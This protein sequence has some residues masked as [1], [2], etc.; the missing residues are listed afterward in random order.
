MRGLVVAVVIILSVCIFQALEVLHAVHFSRRTPNE[1]FSTA[2][3]VLETSET[4]AMVEKVHVE[5]NGTKKSRVDNGGVDALV[6]RLDR[7]NVN[8]RDTLTGSGMVE[9][10]PSRIKTSELVPQNDLAT[11]DSRDT[12]TGRVEN[13][14]SGRA[15]EPE[16][17]TPEAESAC[18]DGVAAQCPHLLRSFETGVAVRGEIPGIDGPCDFSCIDRMIYS[19]CISHLNNAPI[20]THWLNSSRYLEQR[21]V[22]A[23]SATIR[24]D[25][26]QR[27]Y[28]AASLR[29]AGKV[30][31]KWMHSMLG[32]ARVLTH[33]NGPGSVFVSIYED[34]STDNTRPNLK[35]LRECLSD[36]SIPHHILLDVQEN[37]PAGM[38]IDRMAV[39]RERAL[40]KLDKTFDFVVF[41]N[42]INFIPENILQLIYTNAPFDM[43]CGMDHEHRFDSKTPPAKAS[44]RHF[45]DVWVGRDLEGKTMQRNFPWFAHPLDQMLASQGV[46]LPV[47]CCWNGGVVVRASVFTESNIHFR[48]AIQNDTLGECDDSECS[49]FCRDLWRCDFRAQNPRYSIN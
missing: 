43:V 25:Q 46:P 17:T 33:L 49:N 37:S 10:E 47:G 18:P 30:L 16:K 5:R 14:T 26:K 42:D 12:P 22:S 4:M 45:Y 36:A 31:P 28:I 29:N 39:L 6:P 35:K 11:F 19:C 32:L 1:S 24:M 40:E 27:Y 44:S 41:L 21:M 20:A 8:T 23:P 38:R 7:E 34:G 3:E 2:H 9:N 13:E 15:K 48:R